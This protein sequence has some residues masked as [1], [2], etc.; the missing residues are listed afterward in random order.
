MKIAIV[1]IA[2][3]LAT[4]AAAAW[5][6]FSARRKE[7]LLIDVNPRAKCAR[8]KGF[9]QLVYPNT[10]FGCY[11]ED[12]GQACRKQGK[13]W[14]TL[15]SFIFNGD[16]RYGCF[17]PPERWALACKTLGLKMDPSGSYCSSSKPR[18]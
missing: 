1:A 2:L 3:V 11:K 16:Q 4:V 18:K 17:S 6:W 5:W 12:Q 14:V 10:T 8:N 15:D 7:A 13:Q 9:W